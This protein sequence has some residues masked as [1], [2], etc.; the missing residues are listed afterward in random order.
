MGRVFKWGGVVVACL[1]LLLFVL[2]TV[3]RLMPVPENEAKALALL[4]APRPLP[5]RNGLAALWLVAHDV[6]MKQAEHLLD[7]EVTRFAATPIQNDGEDTALFSLALDA[8]PRLD[9]DLA[10]RAVE[11]RLNETD[12][13]DKMRSSL[14]EYE[15][16]IEARLKVASRMAALDK[17]DYFRNPFPYRFDMPIPSYQG[18]I[19]D[20]SIHAYQFVRGDTE[21][22]L[23]GVCRDASIA[24]KLVASGD[25]LIG[26]MIGAAM[27]KGA[28]QLFVEM[29]AELPV[30]HELPADCARVFRPDGGMTEAICPTM[31]GEGRFAAGGLRSIYKAQADDTW[32]LSRLLVDVEKTAA[33]GAPSSTWCCGKEARALIAADEPLRNTRSPPSQWSLSCVSNAMGCILTDIQTPAYADYG[34]RLQDAEVRQKLVGTWLWLREHAGDTRSLVERL[35]SRPEALKS[36][37]RDIHVSDDGKALVVAMYEPRRE[38]GTWQLPIP[39]WMTDKPMQ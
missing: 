26:S 9:G 39:D 12:C 15:R 5:G 24:R 20:P 7:E 38:A 2:Y 36:P 1:M 28:S 21:P 3:G 10:D 37:A 25:N 30:D 27:M 8:L 34:L 17:Y 23:E 6:P 29:L 33:R 22:A 18:L 32:R 35:A 31:I 4:D 11:C 19:R 16:H 13:L 14:P